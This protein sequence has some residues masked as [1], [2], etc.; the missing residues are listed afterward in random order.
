MRFS[1]TDRLDAYDRYEE[2]VSQNFCKLSH[3][4]DRDRP[5]S[6]HSTSHALDGFM[7]ARVTTTGG[8]SELIRTEAAIRDDMRGHF[9]LHI[10]LCGEI[11]LHQFSRQ[12]RCAPGTMAMLSVDAPYVQRKLGDNDTVYF[13]LPNSFVDRRLACSKS[14]CS[15]RFPTQSG[16]GRLVRDGVVSLQGAA[17]GMTEAQFRT[18]ARMLGDMVLMAIGSTDA[19]SDE[20]PLRSG[21]L[22]RA[23]RLIHAEL[24]NADITIKDIARRCGI[25]LRYLHEIFHTRGTTVSEYIKTQRLQKARRML[26]T[27]TTGTTV[28]EICFQC[29]FSNASQFSTAF[30]QAFAISPRDVLCSGRY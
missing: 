20:P 21:I 29:G 4:L 5:F 12:E 30:R 14:A 16:M 25:S 10:P 15:R 19:V 17:A 6:I 13:F 11:E 2:F 9:V 22:A 26:E 7:V 1:S 8:K 18:S 24:G 28:T 3:R 27:A 23:E